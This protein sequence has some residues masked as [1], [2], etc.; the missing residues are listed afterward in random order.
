MCFAD[1]DRGIPMTKQITAS[2]AG[3]VVELMVSPGTQ[4]NSGQ[5]VVMLESMK[6]QLPINSEQSGIVTQILVKVGDFVN[7]GDALI[8]LE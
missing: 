6:M 2:M 4:I 1:I 7:E 5:E 8:A 3:V